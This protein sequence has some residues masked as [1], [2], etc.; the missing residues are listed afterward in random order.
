[1]AFVGG[2]VTGYGRVGASSVS[3]GSSRSVFVAGSVRALKQ[4]PR[5]R[6]AT[7]PSMGLFGLGFPELLVIGG[8]T[9]LIFGPNKISE[10]GKNLG[11]VAGSVKKATSEFQDAMQES[12]EQADKEIAEQKESGKEGEAKKTPTTE[13]ATTETKKEAKKEES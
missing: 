3:C 7:V 8:V 2:L 6:M 1:M 10:L 9:A 5:P 11:S 4:K 13:T 12:L